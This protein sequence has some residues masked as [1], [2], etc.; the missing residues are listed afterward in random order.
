[1][2]I[3]II[4]IALI[5]F[6]RSFIIAAFRLYIGRISMTTEMSVP[7]GFGMLGLTGRLMDLDSFDLDLNCLGCSGLGQ[8][9][10]VVVAWGIVCGFGIRVQGW[11]LRD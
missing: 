8:E 2:C 10:R 6:W 1:M 4:K 3:I 9:M 7:L 5:M 11:G